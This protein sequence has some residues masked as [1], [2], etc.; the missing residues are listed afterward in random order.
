MKEWIL[1]GVEKETIPNCSICSTKIKWVAWIRNINTLEEIPVGSTCCSNMISKI[2]SKK[3]KWSIDTLK[4]VDKCKKKLEE[5]GDKY[6]IVK[7]ARW[8]SNHFNDE[9]F[10]KHFP[11]HHKTLYCG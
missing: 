8:L 7:V 9:N 4:E 3:I 1:I 5:W 6:P 11:I 10:E 2:D